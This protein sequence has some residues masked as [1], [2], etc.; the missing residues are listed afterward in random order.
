MVH[1]AAKSDFPIFLPGAQVSLHR[2]RAPGP[3]L[4]TQ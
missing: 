3:G 4:V 2:S 1:T